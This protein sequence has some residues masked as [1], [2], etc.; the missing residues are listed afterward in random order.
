MLR[1]AL[2]SA[3]N[4]FYF[5]MLSD[6]F[7]KFC[8]KIF[9]DE[10]VIR[11]QNLWIIGLVMTN[12]IFLAFLIIVSFH[13]QVP[14]KVLNKLGI[15]DYKIYRIYP[16]YGTNNIASLTFSHKNYDI[17]MI[18]DSI[19]YGGDWNILLDN[20]KVAN[21]GIGGVSTDNVLNR[22]DDVYFLE[23]KICFIMK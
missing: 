20:E 8:H 15:M 1:I 9:Y 10:I 11:W 13:Y 7:S 14:Q 21:L 18:G 6:I 17:V 23:P 16:E 3:P 22:L 12:V 4:V 19:T 5:L 2:L